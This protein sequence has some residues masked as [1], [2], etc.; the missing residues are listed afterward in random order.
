LASISATSEFAALGTAGTDEAAARILK[1][2]GLGADFK[3]W[4][5]KTGN[6]SAAE[7]LR[8]RAGTLK[9]GLDDDQMAARIQQAGLVKAQGQKEIE[10]MLQGGFAT[11]GKDGK[12]SLSANTMK[13][14]DKLNPQQQNM[15][16]QMLEVAQTKSRVDQ[17]S[18][19][20][21]MNAEADMFAKMRGMSVEE[22][23]GMAATLRASGQGRMAAMFEAE[24]STSQR[25]K[26]SLDKKGVVGGL[27]DELGVDISPERKKAIEAAQKSGDYAKASQLLYSELEASGLNKGV[28]AG[29]LEQAL[30]HGKSQGSKVA[31][32]TGVI[33]GIQESE[34]FKEAKAKKAKQADEAKNPL[35]AEVRDIL[36]DISK[37]SET[38]AKASKT[39]AQNTTTLADIGANPKDKP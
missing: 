25:I 36:K 13:D 4:S 20:G 23:R 39:T 1:E 30:H 3:K 17:G 24:A 19:G 31:D 37:Q 12:L 8:A 7:F 35:M 33:K 28:S 5:G 22:Q 34:E 11:M 26:K 18:L 9:S 29:Q 21:A 6:G 16:R 15:M 10:A 32:A 27:A 38:T 2:S 14:F